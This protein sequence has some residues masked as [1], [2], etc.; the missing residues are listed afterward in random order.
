MGQL[1]ELSFLSQRGGSLSYLSQYQRQGR[2]G[3]GDAE[4]VAVISLVT[5]QLGDAVECR[6]RLAFLTHFKVGPLPTAALSAP[7]A[8]GS[9]RLSHLQVLLQLGQVFL[10]EGFKLRVLARLRLFLEEGDRLLVIPNLL[11][12][13]L[14]VE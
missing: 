3:R 5:E 12:D 8:S 10:G 2:R 9:Q 6:K 13:V 7:L 14:P 4:R 1:L 11:L